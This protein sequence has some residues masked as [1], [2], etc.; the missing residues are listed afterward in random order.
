[1][2]TPLTVILCGATGWAG[3]ALA[4]GIARQPDLKLVGA[5]GARSAGRRLGEVLGDEA[6]DC[7]VSPTAAAALAQSPCEV[8]VEYSKPKDIATVKA[9]IVAALEAG[10]HVVVATSG[11]SDEDYADIDRVARAARRGVLACGNFALTVVLLQRFAEMAAAY[12]PNFEVI[13]YAKDSKPDAPSGTVRELALRLGRV[14]QPDLGVPLDQVNGPAGVRGATVN[15][16]QV[17]ALRV[18]GFVLGV[19]VVFGMKDQRLHLSHQAGTSAE[20]YVDGALLAIRKV[21]GLTGVVRGLDR[22]MDL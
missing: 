5:V 9:N 4:R 6:L 7:V 10:A 22:V 11:L 15:G 14:R 3:S 21:G 18:P 20:P 1:M 8:Y 17:H 16:V 2:N 13:D 19:E 12:I